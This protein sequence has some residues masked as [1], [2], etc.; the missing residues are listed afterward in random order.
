MKKTTFIL[1][2]LMLPF[3]INAQVHFTFD[4]S[5]DDMGVTV[6]DATTPNTQT[7]SLIESANEN[8]LESGNMTS[9][10]VTDTERGL[11]LQI[12]NRYEYAEASTLPTTG[13][14][15]MSYWFKLDSSTSYTP[16]NLV[17]YSDTTNS[18]VSIVNVGWNGGK[19][20][21]FLN[22]ISGITSDQGPAFVEGEWNHFVSAFD[23]SENEITTYRNGVFLETQSFGNTYPFAFQ[24]YNRWILGA[25]WGAS[26]LSKYD[27]FMIHSSLL[28]QD[29]VTELYN[30]QTLSTK[31]EIS[32][33]TQI[34]LYPN[35]ANSLLKIK[36]SS[37]IQIENVTM[38]NLLGKEIAL[39]TTPSKNTYDLSKLPSGLYLVRISDTAGNS[40]TKRVIKN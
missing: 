7:L 15:T 24:N 17:F 31:D 16:Y 30:N 20:A 19:S 38:H 1:A 5:R 22:K 26:G 4:S 40:V 27:D 23:E 32:F 28:D 34:K 14:W 10:I 18:L 13:D 36:T 33:E 9:G 2:F 25:D 35:P 39:T 21:L 3:F 6:I 8:N 11:V 37:N 12:A 29:A